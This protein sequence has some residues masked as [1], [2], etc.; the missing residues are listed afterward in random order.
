MKMMMRTSVRLIVLL[1][2]DVT[3]LALSLFVASRLLH[4]SFSWEHV[5]IFLTFS[6]ICGL[7]L[8]VFAKFGLYRTSLRHASI[9]FL[10]EILKA[11]TAASVLLIFGLYVT[12]VQAP[13]EMLF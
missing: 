5:Q 3:M 10:V 1:L 9:D 7:Q 8:T 11:T 6:A 2:N 4:F 13:A 12:S